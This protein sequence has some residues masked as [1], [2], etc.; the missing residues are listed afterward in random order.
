MIGPRGAGWI[1]TSRPALVGALAVDALV[2]VA[3]LIAEP[4]AKAQ[5]TTAIR[6]DLAV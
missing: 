2:G 1:V 6:M 5:R 4:P 3:A